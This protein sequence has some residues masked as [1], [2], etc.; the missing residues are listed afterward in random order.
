[1]TADATPGGRPQRSLRSLAPPLASASFQKRSLAARLDDS[2]YFAKCEIVES[3]LRRGARGFSLHFATQPQ[4][5]PLW[6]RPHSGKNWPQAGRA[7]FTPG[8][9]A[10]R[11]FY[12]LSSRQNPRTEAA[13]PAKNKK[14]EQK[15]RLDLK[16][17]NS[18]PRY[19]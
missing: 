15:A 8:G 3:L 4:Q 19:S 12:Y 18:A 10:Q 13:H 16:N 14:A 5:K 11:A 7:A 2:F 9:R 1:M 6:G 17:R